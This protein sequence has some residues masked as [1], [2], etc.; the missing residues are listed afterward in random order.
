MNEGVGAIRLNLAAEAA[1]GASGGHR[2][3][4]A[5]YRRRV[6]PNRRKS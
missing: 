1:L 5:T 2:T 4:G 3:E 6:R